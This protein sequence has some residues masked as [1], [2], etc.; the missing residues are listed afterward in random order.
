[1]P[2][3]GIHDPAGTGPIIKIDN[4]AEVGLQRFAARA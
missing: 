1:M 2:V 4:E 3:A